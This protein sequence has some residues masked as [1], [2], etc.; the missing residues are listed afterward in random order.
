[1]IEYFTPNSKVTLTEAYLYGTGV[2]MMAAVYTFTH[3]PYF[4]GVMYT[5]MKV[6]IACC[7]ILYRK[8]LKLSNTALG[9][10]TI[11]QMVNLLSNDVNRF[12][13]TVLFNH[14]LWAGPLQLIIVTG[15]LC[16]KIGPSALVGAGLLIAAVPLQS[17]KSP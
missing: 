11:G 16:N 7:S 4:F 15:L 12:D 9:Q 6:R 3:H 2:V 10:T 17:K 14:Y 8:A 5:G 13:T 1:M